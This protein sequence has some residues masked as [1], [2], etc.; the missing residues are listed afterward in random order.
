MKNWIL[1]LL[2]LA[3]LGLVL[4]HHLLL[5]IPEKMRGR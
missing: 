5:T 1:M 2:L 4:R 3:E